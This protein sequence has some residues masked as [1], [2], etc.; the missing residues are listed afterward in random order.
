MGQDFAAVPASFAIG[1][2]ESTQVLGVHQTLPAATSDSRFNFGFVETT[3]HTVTVRVTA[4]DGNNADQ[5]FK[6][7][8]VREFSQRQVAFKDHFPTVSTENTRL[9]VEVISGTGKIIA[10]GSGIANGSQDP[11]TFEMTYADALLAENVA[12]GITGVTA[13]AGL[14][15]G[16]ASGVVTLAVADGGITNAMLAPDAVTTS[17]ILN[18]AVATA[19]LADGSVTAAK[20][21]SGQVV[22]SLNGLNDA[23]TL[24]A[25]GAVSITPS[26]NTLTIGSSGLVLPYKGSADP[27]PFASAFTVINSGNGVGVHGESIN[28]WGVRGVGGVGVFGVSNTGNGFGVYGY[29]SHDGG[30][31]VFGEG[32]DRGV[33]GFSTNGS[34]V[35]GYSD[36]G[37]GV[38]GSGSPGV[39][40]YSTTAAGSGV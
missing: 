15:G 35:Y 31:G 19:D 1:A 2:G 16:G 10:Y 12:P 30:Y 9:Q 5:G 6:D 18:G 26:G 23:V 37:T 22:K 3:G 27:G 29:N 4:F 17:K 32:A 28:G 40:G 33:P 38:Y 11:T 21:G 20:V 7:F 24:A 25:S 8:T 39:H 14:T 36:D 13:G 34:G